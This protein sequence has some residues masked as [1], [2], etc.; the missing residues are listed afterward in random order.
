MNANVFDKLSPEHQ[1]IIIEAAKEV[2]FNS[3]NYV[4]ALTWDGFSSK[5]GFK[6]VP[7][8]FLNDKSQQAITKARENKLNAFAAAVPS[9]SKEI[10]EKFK[11]YYGGEDLPIAK[12]GRIEKIESEETD[13]KKDK[14]VP[15]ARPYG[16]SGQAKKR[17]FSRQTVGNLKKVFRRKSI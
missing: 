14:K 5:A 13:D 7:A 4:G 2:S 8:L 1:K 6:D 17:N 3:Y 11:I 10:V 12:S 9:L 16:A 15:P